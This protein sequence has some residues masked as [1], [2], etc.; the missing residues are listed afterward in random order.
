MNID[1]SMGSELH[2]D[3]AYRNYELEELYAEC[4]QIKLMVARKKNR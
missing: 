2:A 4:E 1:V 3:S